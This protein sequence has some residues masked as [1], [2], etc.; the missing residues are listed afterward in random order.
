VP[1]EV[2][3]TTPERVVFSAK[4]ADM[5]IVPGILGEMGFLPNH[6]H[7]LSPLKAGKV[8]IMTKGTQHFLAVSGGFVE[9]S[10]ERVH[11]LAETAEPADQIDAERA[12]RAKERAQQRLTRPSEEINVA[13]AQAALARA[14]NR[15]AAAGLVKDSLLTGPPGNV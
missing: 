11:I 13:R 2:D 12:Q 14:V 7:L 10:P 15:L 3:V 9:A 8:E 4:D 1:L 6:T 5:I